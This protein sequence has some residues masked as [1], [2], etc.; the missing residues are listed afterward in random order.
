MEKRAP[1]VLA[2]K[3]CDRTTASSEDTDDSAAD[4]TSQ[5]SPVVDGYDEA[6]R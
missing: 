1:R 4:L 2:N 5:Y 3:A 6:S